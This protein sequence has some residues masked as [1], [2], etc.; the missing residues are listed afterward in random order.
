MRKRC[1]FCNKM[2]YNDDDYKRITTPVHHLAF[3]PCCNDCFSI[4]VNEIEEYDPKT[5]CECGSDVGTNRYIKEMGEGPDLITN[6]YL[7]ICQDCVARGLIANIRK[8]Y[9]MLD[10]E[11]ELLEPFLLKNKQ[12][13]GLLMA[14]HVHASKAFPGE[15][16]AIQFRDD[17]N[18]SVFILTGDD[19]KRK[20]FQDFLTYII[21][22]TKLMDDGMMPMELND[23]CESCPNRET[24]PDRVD[25]LP[26]KM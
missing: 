15:Q 19:G 25:K 10:E 8:N 4:H 11:K 26:R 21:E 9:V 23:R 22:K 20:A 3:I 17:K 18:L 14:L 24:C 2:L 7:K 5:C 12:D 16:I 1:C 13:I 6:V